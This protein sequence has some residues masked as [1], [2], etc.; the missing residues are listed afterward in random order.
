MKK[1]VV[2]TGVLAFLTFGASAW[3]SFSVPLT[4]LSGG[5]YPSGPPDVIVTNQYA[6]PATDG[7][8]FSPSS[9]STGNVTVGSSS[10]TL[11]GATF[12]YATPTVATWYDDSSTQVGDG[13]LTGYI[14]GFAPTSN[15]IGFNK[16]TIGG[17]TYNAGAAISFTS[18][19]S[20]LQFDLY[21]PGTTAG[22][23]SVVTIDLFNG[24][25]LVGTGT[26]QPFNNAAAVH[27]DSSS[28]DSTVAFN[29]VV[30]SSPSRFMLN[31]INGTSATPIPNSAWLLG[32]AGL[33][34][35]LGIKRRHL[36]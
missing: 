31:D 34:G 18:S 17:V 21:R 27:F 35:I 1:L 33:V 3:A 12:G 16:G 10:F 11:G 26:E 23:S 36:A 20:D 6:A 28:L 8:T 25:T 15:F 24:T 13:T 7:I 19:L 32:A 2:L 22:Q 30:L 5:G 4:D 14:S 29:E 9:I